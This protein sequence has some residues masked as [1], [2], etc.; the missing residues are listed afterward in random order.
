MKKSVVIV[1]D[2]KFLVTMLRDFFQDVMN[3]DVI[4]T[5]NNGIHAV[6]LYRKHKPDLLTL[7]LTMPIK[8]G[9][10]AL[11]EILGEF[12]AA[13]ILIISALNGSTILECIK[14]GARAYIEKPLRLDDE[15]FHNDFRQTLEEAFMERVRK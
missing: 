5:G 4:A 11:G 7:D 6:E 9:Q 12:P 14:Q 13:R 10:T 15:D 1:D 2:S 8:D 3:F